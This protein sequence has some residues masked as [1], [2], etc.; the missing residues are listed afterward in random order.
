MN[1]R[2]TLS[3]VTLAILATPAEVDAQKYREETNRDLG[4]TYLVHAKLS[5]V[6]E[7]I[8]TETSHL[9]Q[10]FRP[11]SNSDYISGKL[12]SYEWYTDVYRFNKTGRGGGDGV[13]GPTTGGGDEELT[14]EEAFRRA[15]LERL[16]EGEAN[17][18]E[19][20]IHDEDKDD[21]YLHREFR[22]EGKERKGNERQ[23]RPDATV[24]EFYDIDRRQSFDGRTIELIWYSCAA[25]YDL[26]D[27]EVAVVVRTPIPKSGTKLPSKYRKIAYK[28]I[29]SVSLVE[30]DEIAIEDDEEKDQYADTP[31]KK[32]MLGILKDNI[33]DVRNRW[34]YFTLPHYIV[35]FSWEDPNSRDD[36]VRS[37]NYAVWVAK[38]VEAMRSR[39]AEFYPP[40]DDM[41]E[42]YSIIRVCSNYEEF[43]SYGN[44]PR[45]VVGWFS[46]GTKELVV[47][48]DRDKLFG[49]D[50]RETTLGVVFHEAWHQYSDQW[51]PNSELHRWFDEGLAEF[52]N[53]QRLV[54]AGRT[55]N[56]WR[57]IPL[58]GRLR[59][60]KRMMNTDTLV[61]T[62]TIVHWP[63]S[64]FYGG[65]AADHYA[66]AYVMVDFLMRGK[67]RLGRKFDS[68]FEDII[69]TYGEECLK[70][71]DPAEA[72]TI[73]FEGVDMDVYDEAWKA[74]YTEGE[75]E[76]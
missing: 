39:Y 23:R 5:Q 58:E 63:R 44:T 15:R 21:L 47:F 45:G 62:E 76:R 31:E 46:P 19:E 26:G 1:S 11:D 73:A 37:H 6:P 55:R 41:A 9:V 12:G 64:S 53:G 52:F 74:W 68:S 67:E 22:V 70:G 49:S 51:W 48:F 8:G 54:R 50:P 69:A 25:V 71:T 4:I 56:T 29:M 66:Q 72:M 32:K 60:V 24:W 57:F 27:K 14:P 33:K 20:Y 28:T 65:A 3:L 10:K 7:Q 43:G 16:A 59:A 75:I 2:L 34:D 61:D 40:H 36:R 30:E 13:D 42:N 38:Q 35:T 17:S 18:F